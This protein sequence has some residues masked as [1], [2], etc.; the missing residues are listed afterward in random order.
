[1]WRPLALGDGREKMRERAEKE[2][3]QGEWRCQR[4]DKEFSG[5]QHG[6]KERRDKREKEKMIDRERLALREGASVK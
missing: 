3:V 2:R 1:M 6:G 5:V 4:E